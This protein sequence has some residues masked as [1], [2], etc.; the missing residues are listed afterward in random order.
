MIYKISKHNHHKKYDFHSRTYF[1]YVDVILINIENPTKRKSI[2]IPTSEFNPDD[3]QIGFKYD[4]K[5]FLWLEKWNWL[6]PD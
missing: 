1:N 3:Y 4:I 2:T 6:Q 5:K